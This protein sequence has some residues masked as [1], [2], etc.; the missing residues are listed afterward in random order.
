M[1]E[2]PMKY[3]SIDG[4]DYPYKCTIG[5]LEMIQAKYVDVLLFEDGII[6]R[7]PVL[8]DDGMRVADKAMF[9][10]PKVDMVCTG[11]ELM[12]KAGIRL[13]GSEL[14]P[15]AAEYFKDQDE[16]TLN[17]LAQIVFEEYTRSFFSKSRKK[18]TDSRKSRSRS[19]N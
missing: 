17:E 4:V 12:I 9:T 7:V 3:I 19:K 2:K 1:I 15:V 18:V 14:E 13:T 5:V 16:Y 11:L 10:V 6:G 8:D